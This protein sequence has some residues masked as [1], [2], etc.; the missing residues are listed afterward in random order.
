MAPARGSEPGESEDIGSRGQDPRVVT[1]RPS[2]G[3]AARSGLT[4]TGFLGDSDRK[5][6]RRVYLHRDLETFVEFASEDVVD[7]SRIAADQAPFVGEPAT[8]VTLKQGARFEFTRTLTTDDFRL[9]RPVVAT[10]SGLRS[11]FPDSDACH[12]SHR[13][14][15]DWF[16]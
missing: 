4:L 3:D 6:Y 13:Y 12:L 1:G 8:L 14:W 11:P 7:A 9:E 15:C 5:G 16:P 2:P 10:G